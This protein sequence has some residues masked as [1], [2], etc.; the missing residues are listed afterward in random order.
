M[1]RIHEKNINP[2]PW[3]KRRLEQQYKRGDRFSF[4]EDVAKFIEEDET[5]LDV[6]AGGGTEI[7]LLRKMGLKNKFDAC[8]ISP[9]SVDFL[10]SKSLNIGNCFVCDVLKGIDRPDNSYDIVTAFELIEHFE[11]PSVVVKELVR[12][13]RK[14]VIVSCP[15]KNSFRHRQHH[16]SIDI[17]DIR[18]FNDG[19]HCEIM[20]GKDRTKYILAIYYV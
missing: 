13:A 10:R 15:Y 12:V 14:K 11:D 19:G 8:D 3:S 6:G 16:W 9:T 2:V 17:N 20:I 1:K 5:I 4:T 18:A 7:K